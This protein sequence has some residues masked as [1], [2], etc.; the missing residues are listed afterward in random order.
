MTDWL[1]DD[2][3]TWAGRLVAHTASAAEPRGRVHLRGT[4]TTLGPRP[5]GAVYQHLPGISRGA[6]VE[7]TV[8]DGTGTVVLRWLGRRAIPG[9]VP[10]VVVEVE[11]TLALVRGQRVILNPLYRFLDGTGTGGTDDC[12]GTR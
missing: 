7:A 3:I 5:A 9:M 12:S 1:G 6:V 11:G 4:V 2:A 8:D 10:G